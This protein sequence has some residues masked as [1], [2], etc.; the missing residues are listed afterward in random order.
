MP[1]AAPSRG[2]HARGTCV[3]HPPPVSYQYTMCVS[4]LESQRKRVV[5]L[6]DEPLNAHENGSGRE[7]KWATGGCGQR[8][9]LRHVRHACAAPHMRRRDGEAASGMWEAGFHDGEAL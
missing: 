2:T 8:P 1:L 9:H 5:V 4:R 6:V 7:T 3:Q